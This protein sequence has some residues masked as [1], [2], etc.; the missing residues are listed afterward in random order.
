MPALRPDISG[1]VA[2]SLNGTTLVESTNIITIWEWLG[3]GE[4]RHSRGK[5]FWRDGAGLNVSLDAEKGCWFDHAESTGGGKLDLIVQVQHCSRHD[6]LTWLSGMSGIALDSIPLTEE[7]RERWRD[8]QRVRI[9]AVYFKDAA[10]VLAEEILEQLSPVDPERR[11]Y[12]ALLHQ[13]NV[14]PETEYREWR[15]RDLTLTNALVS[16][17]RKREARLHQML[18]AFLSKDAHAAA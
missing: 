2:S 7:D 12:T 13:L 9:D 6:A 16:A 15:D 3:G 8:D 11:T 18:A 14:S 4:L 10:R 5:A 1:K 17:G